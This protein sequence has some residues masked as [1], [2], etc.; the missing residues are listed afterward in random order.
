MRDT[1][2]S[3]SSIVSLIAQVG[4]GSRSLDFGGAFVMVFLIH[5]VVGGENNNSWHVHCYGC[6]AA[7]QQFANS[8]LTYPAFLVMNV[9]NVSTKSDFE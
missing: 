5:Y 6:D 2:G 4:A 7:I 1:I 8:L 3:S 9:A